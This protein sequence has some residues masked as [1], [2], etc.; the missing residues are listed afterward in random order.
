MKVDTAVFWKW[1]W[2]W[3]LTTDTRD[4]LYPHNVDN[5]AG[6][7]ITGPAIDRSSGWT[8]IR[9]RTLV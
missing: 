4:S 3:V 7:T 2:T 8:G 5:V 9:H 6:K 1:R